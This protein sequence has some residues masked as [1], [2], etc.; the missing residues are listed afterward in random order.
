MRETVDFDTVGHRG[1]HPSPASFRR[2]RAAAHACPGCLRPWAVR[3]VRTTAGP[4]V[5][6]CW[7]CSWSDVRGGATDERSAY[8]SAPAPWIHGVHRYDHGSELIRSLADYL[9]EGW[10]SG[11]IGVV[12]ASPDH[13]AALRQE[14]AVRGL[15]AALGGGRLVELDAIETLR[16]FMR[17]GSSD[18]VLFQ[19]T[20]GSLVGERAAGAPLRAFGEMVDVLWEA[21]NPFAALKLERLWAGLQTRVPFSLLC[22]YA[23]GHLDEA[24]R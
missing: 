24:G 2:R 4:W 14:L 12:V 20:V 22:G 10:A 13:R 7:H 3:A 11:R 19:E 6:S 15:S 9:S 21:G 16:L 5:Y 8:P 1:G 23:A 18:P 17:D